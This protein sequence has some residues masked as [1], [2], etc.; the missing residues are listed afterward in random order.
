MATDGSSSDKAD[1]SQEDVDVLAYSYVLSHGYEG[2]L[3]MFAGLVASSSRGDVG[4]DDVVAILCR[5]IFDAIHDEAAT[6]SRILD[7]MIPA[8]HNGAC[9]HM[10]AV[11]FPGPN[12]IDRHIGDRLRRRRSE[13]GLSLTGLAPDLAMTPDALALIEEGAERLDAVTLERAVKRRDVPAV[14]FFQPFRP[15]EDV[16]VAAQ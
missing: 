1:Y 13:L 12:P 14:Y 6:I 15:D 7:R 10:A 11:S 5:R 8:L 9:H 2:A 3:E 4:P 16:S